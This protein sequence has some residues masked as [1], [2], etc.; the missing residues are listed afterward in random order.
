M[1]A[2]LQVIRLRSADLRDR[3]GPASNAAAP[4]PAG[5]SSA[6]LVTG[7]PHA[8]GAGGHVRRPRRE[9]A[10]SPEPGTALS[11]VGNYAAIT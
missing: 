8:S 1:A 4:M 11:R 5:I 10:P 9:G 7:S 6:A 2:G 3:G